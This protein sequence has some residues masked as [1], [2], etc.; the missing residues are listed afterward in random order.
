MDLGVVG[1]A[2][3]QR[4]EA[5]GP[6]KQTPGHRVVDDLQQRVGLFHPRRRRRPIGL[7]V[8]PDDTAYV[9]YTSGSTGRPKG[10]EVSHLNVTR[11]I[12]A[13]VELYDFRSDDRWSMF[14]SIA[15]DVS[16]YEIWGA[17]L[18]GAA[19]VVV[20]Y[21]LSRNP[22]A[23]RE[24][25]STER[26]TVL[27]QTPSAFRLVRDAETRTR[28]FLRYVIFAGE[29]LTFADLI[30]WVERHG[31]EQPQLVNMYGIT[32]TTVHVTFRRLRRAEILAARNSN[33]GRP[34]P[35]LECLLVDPA[36]NLVP[37]GVPGEICVGGP[38]VAKGYFGRPELT[39]A[40][41]V[42]HPL[43]PG[44]RIY[45]SGDSGRRLVGGDIE[46]IGRLDHQVKLRG[47]RIE[48]GE[49][50]TAVLGLD[51]VVACHVMVR[52]DGEDPQLVAYIV[53]RDGEQRALPQA[54]RALSARLPDY[55][56][57]SAVVTLESL[58]LN[59]NGKIDRGALPAPRSLAAP[60]PVVDV[61]GDVTVRI[62]LNATLRIARQSA[63]DIG[64]VVEKL[65]KVVAE[66]LELSSV[67]PDDNFFDIGG[68]SMMAVKISAK[69][70]A[71][72]LQVSVQD[73]FQHQTPAELAAG[74]IPDQQPGDT[75]RIE[76]TARRLLR[77]RGSEGALPGARG[78]RTV[79][80]G[81]RHLGSRRRAARRGAR[82]VDGGGGGAAVRLA[83]ADAAGL[84]RRPAWRG[85]LRAE[86]QFS[87]CA[88]RRLE[89]DGVA[90]RIALHL[91][92]VPRDR[93]RAVASGVADTVARLRHARS[94]GRRQPVPVVL[95]AA[96]RRGGA[97]SVPGGADGSEPPARGLS[98]V[99]GCCR[100]GFAQGGPAAPGIDQKCSAG[101]TFGGDRPACRYG[102]CGAAT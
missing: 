88:A 72:G 62:D 91:R 20:P 5:L 53:T 67:A 73:V 25:L 96:A 59:V 65:C 94:G 18:H 78:G 3:Q 61:D 92:R 21:L 19:I 41:F 40:K 82:V 52:T 9:I 43:R 28:Q 63:G 79:T 22:V 81:V 100:T 54:R 86:F 83:D 47:F 23:F 85:P 27:S 7:Q 44:E 87:P 71:L 48:L 17:L 58:P 66:V 42:P 8:E 12:S 97:A 80:A 6:L 60:E 98:A 89:R 36:G 56:L 45:R 84:R 75:A 50:E 13:T 90:A 15:F 57:P 95:A 37:Y 11:L 10:V 49:V 101:G 29:M 35:D 4:P 64:P 102:R 24:L 55:M 46:Y 1:L 51:G 26:V 14:H 70:K 31:D 74:L 34:M 32:E 76:R 93:R 16:V 99:A 38:G 69:A 30:P 2:A 33:V 68:D 39:A 77:P